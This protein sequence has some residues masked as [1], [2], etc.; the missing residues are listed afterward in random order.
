[1]VLLYKKLT[2]SAIFSKIS[3]KNIKNSSN[4]IEKFW[5]KNQ[6]KKLKNFEKNNNNLEKK[7]DF[8]QMFPK[9]LIFFNNLVAATKLLPTFWP[10]PPTALKLWSCLTT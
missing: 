3:S 9:F 7:V 2:K 1:M 8:P 10:T 4:K 5:K 6:R